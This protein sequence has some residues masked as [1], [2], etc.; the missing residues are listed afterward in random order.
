[1]ATRRPQAPKV[2]NQDSLFEQD[3][4][5][6]A[7][8]YNSTPIVNGIMLKDVVLTTGT[9][10]VPHRLGRPFI[11]W[12]VVDQNAAGNVYRDTSDTNRLQDALPLKATAAMTVT[13]WVF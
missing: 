12:K 13:L 5:S 2:R 8:D 6:V 3:A 4:R 11:G 10:R 9:T 1:M 7:R